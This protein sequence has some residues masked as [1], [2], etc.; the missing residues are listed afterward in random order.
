MGQCS[1]LSLSIGRLKTHVEEVK[2]DS[3]T[4]CVKRRNRQH[5]VAIN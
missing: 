3:P 5:N 2:A 4:L 1:S